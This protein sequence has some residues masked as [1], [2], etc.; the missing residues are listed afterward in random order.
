[1]RKEEGADCALYFFFFFFF[2]LPVAPLRI[3]KAA[4]R[5]RFGS[6][7]AALDLR[8]FP[9]AAPMLVARP[10][11]RSSSSSHPSLLRPRRDVS[12]PPAVAAPLE[13]LAAAPDA[14]RSG[15]LFPATNFFN[16]SRSAAARACG[17]CFAPSPSLA[18]LCGASFSATYSSSISTSFT[19]SA[20]F[21]LPCTIR[22]ACSHTHAHTYTHRIHL[23]SLH[24][25]T[26]PQP[27]Y[28]HTHTHTRCC[29][30]SR[31][32]HHV[33]LI[34][35]VLLLIVFLSSLRAPERVLRR[36]P[37]PA[38]PYVISVAGF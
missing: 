25:H 28:T 11:S 34:L 4:F 32:H 2:F 10:V 31:M 5:S 7:H 12:V 14:L 13:A 9:F 24:T 19:A 33:L 6:K 36:K 27:K 23:F 29:F 16:G 37:P 21:A 38:P 18:G 1:M 8:F 20:Y 30:I 35:L 3:D 17:R 15:T 26:I 22:F